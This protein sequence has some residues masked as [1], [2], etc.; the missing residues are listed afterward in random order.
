MSDIKR[1][2]ILDGEPFPWDEPNP[3]GEVVDDDGRV[4]WAAALWADP[5][6]MRCPGCGV[7]LWRE[8]YR[9][10]CPDCGHE[11]ETGNQRRTRRTHGRKGGEE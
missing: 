2:I 10:R 11:C 3:M 5:G 9:V 1:P 8:G 7:A 4:N 6:T